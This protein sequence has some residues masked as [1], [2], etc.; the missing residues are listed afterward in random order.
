MP[1]RPK[2]GPNLNNQV[3]NLIPKGMFRNDEENAFFREKIVDNNILYFILMKQ[4][5]QDEIRFA[6]HFNEK[7]LSFFNSSREETISK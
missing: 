7:L 5:T 2:V 4:V 6:F 3:G 1:S